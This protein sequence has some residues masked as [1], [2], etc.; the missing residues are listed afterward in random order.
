MMYED[1]F[2]VSYWP[3]HQNG[4]AKLC[5]CEGRGGGEKTTHPA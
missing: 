5:V 1:T 4:F 2:L 3:L